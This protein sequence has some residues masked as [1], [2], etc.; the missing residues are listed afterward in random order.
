MNLKNTIA[1]EYPDI[2][3]TTASGVANEGS[4]NPETGALQIGVRFNAADFVIVN[5]PTP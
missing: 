4:R 2:A 5:P 3:V 1:N